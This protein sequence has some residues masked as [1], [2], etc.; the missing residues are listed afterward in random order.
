[1]SELP[2]FFNE[3]YRFKLCAILNWR[4]IC[5]NLSFMPLHLSGWY[6]KY[7]CS[8]GFYP[9]CH[10]TCEIFSTSSI[11]ERF[12]SSGYVHPLDGEKRS[13][14]MLPTFEC[15]LVCAG[16]RCI[17]WDVEY[18]IKTFTFSNSIFKIVYCWGYISFEKESMEYPSTANFTSQA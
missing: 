16:F 2:I 4:Y 15:L 9:I 18:F 14:S 3:I 12:R 7:H 11:R 6:Y 5:Y 17:V 13:G 8:H 1:M 10:N